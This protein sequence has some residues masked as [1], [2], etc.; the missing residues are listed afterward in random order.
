[1]FL[2]VISYNT[3][4]MSLYSRHNFQ[5]AGRLRN[6]YHIGTGRQPDPT[7][8]IYDAYLYVQYLYQGDAIYSP[9]DVL[10]V[11]WSP[12]RMAWARLQRSSCMP[13]LWQQRCVAAQRL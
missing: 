9:W 5:C 6:F 3:A 7:T 10:Q 13:Q 12:V 1:M 2:H 4:A 11:A 8:V